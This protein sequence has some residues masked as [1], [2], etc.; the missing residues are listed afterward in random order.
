MSFLF[1]L[2]KPAPCGRK[3]LTMGIILFRQMSIF[4][5]SSTLV[6]YCTTLLQMVSSS[7]VPHLMAKCKHEKCNLKY[8]YSYKNSTKIAVFL[9]QNAENGSVLQNKLDSEWISMS[10]RPNF[11]KW[12]IIRRMYERFHWKSLFNMEIISGPRF[13]A[14]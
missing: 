4:P 13:L 3:R 5:K 14:K 6:R 8:K 11:F 9:P 2:Q 10:S 1:I 12:S 7:R